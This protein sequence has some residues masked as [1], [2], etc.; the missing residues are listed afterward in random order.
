[1]PDQEDTFTIKFNPQAQE[2]RLK[3]IQVSAGELPLK[4]VIKNLK[5]MVATESAL[6]TQKLDNLERLIGIDA[7]KSWRYVYQIRNLVVL[8]YKKGE[9]KQD[10]KEINKE[11]EAIGVYLRSRAENLPRTIS[12][13]EVDLSFT[14][15]QALINALAGL[16]SSRIEG[17]GKEFSLIAAHDFLAASEAL[18][19]ASGSSYSAYLSGQKSYFLG[20]GVKI[21][22]QE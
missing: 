17:A 20:K 11:L 22:A 7:E 13:D 16:S 14:R 3:D 15:A 19:E 10:I 5:T 2:E 6:L 18:R 8:L 21:L 4:E 12:S 1:M 9:I